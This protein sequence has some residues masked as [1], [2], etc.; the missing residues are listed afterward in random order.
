MGIK[1]DSMSNA[2]NNKRTKRKKHKYVVWIC[3]QKICGASNVRKI[4]L[5]HLIFDDKCDKCGHKIHEPLIK[6]IEK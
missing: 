6:E 4:P 1:E 3:D 2:K 5:D